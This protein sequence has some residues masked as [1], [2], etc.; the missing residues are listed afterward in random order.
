[1]HCRVKL[2]FFFPLNKVVVH[3]YG[4]IATNKITSTCTLVDF[5]SYSHK[6]SE[7][8]KLQHQTHVLQQYRD[9]SPATKPGHRDASPT[10]KDQPVS[11]REEPPVVSPSLGSLSVP[12]PQLNLPST[13]K[14][15]TSIPSPHPASH[16]CDRE[17]RPYSSSGDR[18]SLPGST[19]DLS[20]FH[21]QHPPAILQA[22]TAPTAS[23]QPKTTMLTSARRKPS[24]TTE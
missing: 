23:P 4:N 1:M 20:P 9:T 3:C 18:E 22:W 5:F 10:H 19:I 21:E 12:T 15:T 8:V 14:S 2:S 6:H 17:I 11:V 24:A 13:W 7:E 16:T